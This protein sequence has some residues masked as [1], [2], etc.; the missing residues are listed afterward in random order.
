MLSWLSAE[1]VWIPLSTPVMEPALVYW[2]SDHRVLSVLPALTAPMRLP[3]AP[4]RSLTMAETT[5]RA[6]PITKLDQSLRCS[7][8][9]LYVA[10]TTNTTSAGQSFL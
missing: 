7:E 10:S 5:V 4:G 3:S 2:S 8:P 9:S 6:E 1:E